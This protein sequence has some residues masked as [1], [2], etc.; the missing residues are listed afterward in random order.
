MVHFF[1]F[2]EIPQLSYIVD[3]NRRTSILLHV[4]NHLRQICLFSYTVIIHQN[5]FLRY[6]TILRVA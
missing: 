3:C 5:L 1:K 6:I 4:I 2:T